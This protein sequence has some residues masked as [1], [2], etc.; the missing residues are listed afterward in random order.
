M[1]G[2]ISYTQ[3]A[4]SRKK[5]TMVRFGL[6]FCCRWCVSSRIQHYEWQKSSTLFVQIYSLVSHIPFLWLKPNRFGQ[7]WLWQVNWANAIS[8]SVVEEIDCLL[9]Y[10]KLIDCQSFKFL[11][12]TH[13]V[14]Y[15]VNL[16]DVEQHKHKYLSSKCFVKFYGILDD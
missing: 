4:K 14:T 1:L 11:C 5:N 15:L 2:F 3:S 7:N 8:S 12:C 6:L 16:V 13:G 10:F 9:K